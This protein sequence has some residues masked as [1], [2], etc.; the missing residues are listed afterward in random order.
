MEY[1]MFMALRQK[2]WFDLQ[3]E[4]YSSGIKGKWFDTTTKY[5][6][7]CIWITPFNKGNLWKIKRT[8][9]CYYVYYGTFNKIY[10]TSFKDCLNYINKNA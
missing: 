3:I 2:L 8:F 5:D 1:Q 4:V 9:K 7:D 6:K 10:A